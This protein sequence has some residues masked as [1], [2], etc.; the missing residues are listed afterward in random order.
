M[1]QPPSRDLPI[2]V[3]ALAVSLAVP[4]AAAYHLEGRVRRGLEPALSDGL[5][6][7]VSVGSIEAGLTG[8]VRL[9]RVAVGNAFYAESIEGSVSLSSLL[10]GSLRADEVRIERP[11]VRVHIDE[12][13]HSNLERI[14]RNASAAR[15]R[16]RP[17]AS[18]PARER[19]RPPRI[20]V[21]DGDLTVEVGSRGAL[22]LSDVEIHPQTDG[23]RVVVG[24]TA[25]DLDAGDWAVDGRFTRA[26]GDLL[27]PDVSFDRVLAV[28]GRLTIRP[29]RGS[30]TELSEAILARRAGSGPDLSLTAHVDRPGGRSRFTAVLPTGTAP[31]L[32][33]TGEDMPLAALAPLV[34]GSVKLQRSLASGRI[35]ITHSAPGT[36]GLEVDADVRDV[37]VDD[38]R[39]ANLP[40]EWSGHTA[41]RASVRGRDA[42]REIEL[43]QLEVTVGDLRADITGRLRWPRGESLPRQGELRAALPRTDCMKALTSLPTPLR[44]RLAGLSARGQLSASAGLE[45]DID[46]PDAT[47]LDVD[48]DVADCRVLSEASHADPRALMNP[49]EHT[50][51]NGEKRTVGYGAGEYATLKSL[52]AYLDGAFVAAEDARFFDHHGFDAR[53]IE[54]SL[55]IDL[56]QRAIVRGGS[57]ISQQLVKNVFLVHD[58]S[59]SRKLQEA[60]LTW[61]LEA[62]LGKRLILERYLNII[63]LGDGIYGLSEA[64]R[65]WFGKPPSELGVGE[66]AFLAAL[67]PA[68]RSISARIRRAGGID[69]ETQQRVRVVL[70]HMRHDGVIDETTYRRA[71]NTEIQLHTPLLADRE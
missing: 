58:R 55:A 51:P 29:T 19:R 52:P 1:S 56:Q 63:E 27:L 5:G 4:M 3:A 48:V 30:P 41:L 45:F 31:A 60:I 13:G 10:A 7:A 23:V 21:S 24:A 46:D 12:H 11:R 66:A 37:T 26:A 44:D 61:R 15:S 35:A 9:E 18:T 57:T 49:F 54:S 64:A 70:R 68:P 17:D 22:H 36:L 47:H 40:V 25:I 43:T 39:V 71:R 20:V 42:E 50:F 69:P 32:V 67:T 8:A 38:P 16:A 28:G 53:Q 33:V 59:L 65:Y 14:A 2:L 62:H 34:P 6:A